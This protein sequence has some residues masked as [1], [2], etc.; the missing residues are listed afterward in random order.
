MAP[1]FAAH[2][3]KE[4]THDG[5]QTTDDRRPAT[6]GVQPEDPTELPDG[7][8]GAGQTLHALAR[9]VERGGGAGLL[10]AP[11]QRAQIGVQ[12]GPNLSLRH[13]VLLHQD[14]A[15]TVGLSGPGASGQEQETAGGAV[16]G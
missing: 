15:A 8:A 7:G 16:T 13:Q 5:P 3:T 6:G 14:L 9:R 4:M 12:Y 1:H 10:S 11:D 2:F